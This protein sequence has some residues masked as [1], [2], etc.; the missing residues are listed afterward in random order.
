MNPQPPTAAKKYYIPRPPN[1]VPL[2]MEAVCSSETPALT[3]ATLRN[4]PED[5]I[6]HSYRRENIKSYIA[7]TGWIL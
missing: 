2:M 4:I 5:G 1:L 7:L 6:L 3:R